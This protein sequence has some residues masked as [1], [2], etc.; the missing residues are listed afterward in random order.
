MTRSKRDIGCDPGNT[1]E[2][3]TGAGRSGRVDQDRMLAGG[4]VERGDSREDRQRVDHPSPKYANRR[5]CDVRRFRLMDRSR[6][7]RFRPVPRGSA[8]AS[9]SVPVISGGPPRLVRDAGCAWL[10][11]NGPLASLTGRGWL[12]CHGFGGCGSGATGQEPGDC[13]D[14][15]D[16]QGSQCVFQGGDHGH[17]PFVLDAWTLPP[18]ERWTGDTI[19]MKRW[20]PLHI[21]RRW[22][23][24]KVRRGPMTMRWVVVSWPDLRPRS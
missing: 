22:E 1:A 14:A 8:D 7:R 9:Q 21:E 4:C 2:R 15:H 10:G 11:G 6:C 3:P 5:L 16:D 12:C 18:A 13:Q 23:F 20:A 17:I 19:S 24:R